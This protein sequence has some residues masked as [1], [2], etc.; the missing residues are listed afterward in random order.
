[1][2]KPF[3]LAEL[4]ARLRALLRRGK[5]RE[6]ALRVGDLEIDTVRRVVRRAGRRSISS[7][8]STRCSSS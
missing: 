8:R 7:R 2:V 3:A 1:M 5:P 4:S 6:N